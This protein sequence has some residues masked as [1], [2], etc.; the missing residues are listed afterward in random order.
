[1]TSSPQRTYAV[2]ADAHPT[3]GNTLDRLLTSLDVTPHAFSV[4]RIQR[5]WRMMYPPFKIMTVHFVLRGSGQVQFVGAPPM[6]FAPSSVLII[7]AKQS[8][9]VGD[10]DPGAQVGAAADRCAQLGDGLVEFT[11]GSGAGDTLLLCGA[12]S[13]PYQSAL[14]LFDLLRRPLVEQISTGAVPPSI[15]EA[16]RSEIAQP[17]IGTQAMCQA[18]MKQGLIAL[19]RTYCLREDGETLLS[20]AL[21]HP[22]LARV[23]VAVLENPAG[24][25]TVDSLASL[26]CM[27]RA[28][29]SDHFSRAFGQGP[30]DFAQKA[31]LKVAARLLRVTDLPIDVIARSVGYSGARPFSRAFQMAYGHA[32]RTFRNLAERDDLTP[33]DT[34][35]VAKGN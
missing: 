35:D 19:L 7:P 12:I 15:F 33:P 32:P 20:G 1:M 5:G 21:H 10:A 13:A 26:A 17:G 8:H 24:A 27:S 4:C 3:H 14:G 11:A 31:R 2:L 9:W 16:M 23:I 34:R 28:S 25:H 22:R 6:P 29:F 30:V 18:L